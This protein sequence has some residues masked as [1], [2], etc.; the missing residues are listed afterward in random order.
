M[1]KQTPKVK[2]SAIRMRLAGTDGMMKLAY[3]LCLQTRKAENLAIW[4]EKSI[5]LLEQGRHKPLLI[6]RVAQGQR[7][8][9][10]MEND[11][12]L[13]CIFLMAERLADDVALNDPKLKE[14]SA[15]IHSIEK[16]EGLANNE[17]W[18]NDD[19]NSPKD[20]TS[21]TKKWESRHNDIIAAMLKQ[22]GEDAIA[23]LFLNS[24][25]EFD[26]RF[27]TGRRLVFKDGHNQPNYQGDTGSC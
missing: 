11:Q 24:R 5:T 27:E 12:A 9:G 8:A 10:V 14:I 13:T 16:R 22:C 19:P 26:L 3:R 1:K 20:W 7:D 15:I 2:R 23:D 17:Y 6:L 21:L 25:E 18:L 4:R